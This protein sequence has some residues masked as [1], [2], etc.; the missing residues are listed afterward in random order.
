MSQHWNASVDEIGSVMPGD[1]L[2]D[3]P[4]LNATRSITIAAPPEQ[5]FPWI[6][7]MGFGRAGWYSY[8]LVDNLGRRSATRIHPEWQ[9]VFSGDQVPGGPIN[10]TA[11]TVDEPSVFVLALGEPDAGRAR[12]AFTLAYRL[13]SASDGTTTRLVTRVRSRIDLPAGQLTARYL[14][15]TRRWFHA[16]QTTRQSASS[17]RGLRALHEVLTRRCRSRN[18]SGH[19]RRAA[20]RRCH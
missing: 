8:D 19:H 12:V 1:E 7:Q 13:D 2:I 18:R 9:N 5:V 10:F 6:R 4:Q 20:S 3:E 17:C 11:V 15:R 14:L 16:A